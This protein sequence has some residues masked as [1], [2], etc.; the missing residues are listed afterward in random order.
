MI[1]PPKGKKLL[2]D[3]NIYIDAIQVGAE[4][5]TNELLLSTLPRTF[6]SAVV[7]QEL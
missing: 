6:L 5:D 4:G 3:T 2:F 7:V 1:Q